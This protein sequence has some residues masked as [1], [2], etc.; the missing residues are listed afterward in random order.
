MLSVKT[1]LKNKIDSLKDEISLLKINQEKLY[2]SEQKAR[3]TLKLVTK[4]ANDFK[5]K[6]DSLED[7]IS[8]LVEG[9]NFFTCLYVT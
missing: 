7:K 6:N 3:E 9:N 2:F 5:S 1:N 8:K 4:Q